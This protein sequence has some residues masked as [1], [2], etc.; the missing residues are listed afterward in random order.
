MALLTGDR[1]PPEK[2]ASR[3]VV[4]TG[5]LPA[6]FFNNGTDGNTPTWLQ[7]QR[8]TAAGVTP[9]VASAVASLVFGEAA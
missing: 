2:R 6:D 1:S 7:I 8:L 4:A 3:P 9:V 5:R